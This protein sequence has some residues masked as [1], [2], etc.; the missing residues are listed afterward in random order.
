MR[1]LTTKE[2]NLIDDLWTAVEQWDDC[3]GEAEGG[4][5]KCNECPFQI[6]HYDPVHGGEYYQCL[7]MFIEQIHEEVCT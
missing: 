6:M 2:E 3:D 7:K 4:R 1:N 5:T